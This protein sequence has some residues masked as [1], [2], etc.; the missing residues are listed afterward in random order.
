[1]RLMNEIGSRVGIKMLT[2][3]YI[4]IYIYITVR[5]INFSRFWVWD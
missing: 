2:Y 5:L 4:Y 3:I 1:M